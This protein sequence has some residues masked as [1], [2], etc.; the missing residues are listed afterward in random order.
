MCI[1][2]FPI[3]AEFVEWLFFFGARLK[4]TSLIL[5]H[6]TR[7]EGFPVRVYWF[8][9]GARGASVGSVV[10]GTLGVARTPVRAH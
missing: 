2:L 1:S 4:F 7:C 5:A 8:I 3:C 10:E 6:S 9:V